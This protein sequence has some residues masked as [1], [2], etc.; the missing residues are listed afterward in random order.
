[1]FLQT[2]GEFGLLGTGC[3]NQGELKLHLPWWSLAPILVNDWHL[4]STSSHYSLTLFLYDSLSIF[5]SIRIW[6]TLADRVHCI[7]YYCLTIA[8]IYSTL[9][10]SSYCTMHFTIFNIIKLLQQLEYCP[11]RHMDAKNQQS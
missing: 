6:S 3:H 4:F 11:L 7:I 5:C 8:I 2:P 10:S 1:M 9:L